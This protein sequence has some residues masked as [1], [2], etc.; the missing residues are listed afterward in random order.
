MESEVKARQRPT[1]QLLMHNPRE[2]LNAQQLNDG[3][4]QVRNPIG[5]YKNP[6]PENYEGAR[7]EYAHRRF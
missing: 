2:I 6:A 1:K 3:A 5:L 7:R 4:K